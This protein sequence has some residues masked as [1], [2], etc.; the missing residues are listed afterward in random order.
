MDTVEGRLL[1]RAEELSRE[2]RLLGP[3]WNDD[4]SDKKRRAKLVAQL[5]AV[6][7]A[8]FLR[9]QMRIDFHKE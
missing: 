3:R 1:Q 7:T 6:S 2:L 8:L 5:H 9:R 4:E